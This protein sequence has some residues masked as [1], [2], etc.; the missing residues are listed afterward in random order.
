MFLHTSRNKRHETFETQV[1]S[2]PRFEL[3]LLR[4]GA[5]RNL[6]L[7]RLA[8]RCKNLGRGCL[9]PRR[10]DTNARKGDR[11]SASRTSLAGADRKTSENVERP[12]NLLARCR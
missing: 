4:R 11:G 7:L 1:L 2:A 3:L 9:T 10:G 5:L 12:P 6:L 8:G